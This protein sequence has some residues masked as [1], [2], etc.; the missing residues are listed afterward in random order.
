MKNMSEMEATILQQ[1][2][3]VHALSVSVDGGAKRRRP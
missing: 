2:I 3:I 1:D